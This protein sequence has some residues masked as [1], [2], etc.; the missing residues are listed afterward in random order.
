MSN[1]AY[2]NAR[3]G[4]R[5]PP[6]RNGAP[7][8]TPGS[9]STL[10]IWLRADL[11]YNSGAKTWTCQKSGKVFTSSG[12]PTQTTEPTLNNQAVIQFGAGGADGFTGDG[13]ATITTTST[14]CWLF[15]ARIISGTAQY[16]AIYSTDNKGQ[17]MITPTDGN[18]YSQT[19]LDGLVGTTSGASAP[20]TNPFVAMM[21]DGTNVSR[22]NGAA[23]THADI[24]GAMQFTTG[25]TSSV[26]YTVDAGQLAELVVAS[27]STLISLA[28]YILDRYGLTL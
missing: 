10:K 12:T 8:V 24:V 4:R 9:L 5:Y 17:I 20:G 1:R 3:L 13:S 18:L 2:C 23:L 11:G 27:Q 15:V 14:W 25:A 6:R 26:N 19:Q 16:N 28:P 21:G 22:L 7:M